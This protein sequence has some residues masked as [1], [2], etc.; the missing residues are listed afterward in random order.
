MKNFVV[1]VNLSLSLILLSNA[2][3]IFAQTTA[4]VK[5][6]QLQYAKLNAVLV[7]G[8]STEIDSSVI[9]LGKYLRGL[10]V[11]VFEF[12]HPNAIWDNIISIGVPI[13]IF[14]Y[15]GHG[16]LLGV[17]NTPG[18]LAISSPEFISSKVISKDLPLAKNALI[19][20]QSVCFAAGSSASDNSNIPLNTA[21]FRV[22]NY[23]K[24]FIEKGAAA[25]YAVNFT[26]A[27]KP[28]LEDF[29]KGLPAIEIYKQNYS[30]WCKIQTTQC[31]SFDRLYQVSIADQMPTSPATRTTKVNGKT[32]T[33]KVG[34]FLSYEKAFVG[35]P[36]FSVMD[37]FK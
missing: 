20:F 23:A 1:I 34:P 10:G 7:I 8:S 28:F 11:N 24:S 22:E 25:Y 37:F 9:N 32:V 2:K 19:L 31:Y 13:H 30:Q 36:D 16:T 6:T 5:L 27:L 15:R 35:K 21:I 14:V 17:D 12:Y 4:P 26:N 33:K 18:G 29:F 3:N